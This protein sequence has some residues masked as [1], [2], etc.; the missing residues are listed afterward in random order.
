MCVM[1]VLLYMLLKVVKM[2]L[3]FECSVHVSDGFRKKTLGAW[4]E[5][6]L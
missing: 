6:Y 3:W 2:L 5:L 1:C 4:G